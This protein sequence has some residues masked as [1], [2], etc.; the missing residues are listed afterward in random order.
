MEVVKR[1]VPD[2]LFW[3][4]VQFAVDRD[5][6][7]SLVRRAERSGYR[8]L[9][10]TVDSPVLGKKIGPVKRSFYL[11]DGNRF[12]NLEASSENK[13]A[14]VKAMVSVRDAHIDPSQSW[15]DISWLKSITSLPLV[16]KGITS[17]EDA[18]EA[19][20]RGASAIFVSNHGGRQLDGLPATVRSIWQSLT[21]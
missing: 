7:R 12:G 15:D 8:A 5:L 2:G 9:V 11:H 17:A 21:L 4:Q 10:V 19:I 16:L 14:N 3:F 1:E 13:F 20:S 18:K 6:T